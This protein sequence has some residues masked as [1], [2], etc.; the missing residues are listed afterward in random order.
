MSDYTMV[1]EHLFTLDQQAEVRPRRPALGIIGDPGVGKTTFAADAPNVV[2]IMTEQGADGV[3]VRRLPVRGKCETWAEV[4]AAVDHVIANPD[5]V[6]WLALDTL[7]QACELAATHV[8]ERDYNGNWSPKK[9]TECYLSFRQ[10]AETTKK[11]VQGLLA[12]LDE[13]RDLGIG[14]ML[15]CHTGL[16]RQANALGNDFMSFVG[17]MEKQSWD[18]VISWCDQVG[19]ACRD[20]RVIQRQGETKYKAVAISSERWLVFDDGPGRETKSRAGYDMPARIGLSFN[21]YQGYLHS[22]PIGRVIEQ[23]IEALSRAKDEHRVAVLSRLGAD[24]TPDSLRPLGPQKLRQCL[25]W[26]LTKEES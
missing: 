10:G 25:N 1:R 7:S 2:M 23:I 20:E 14:I 22:D 18:A 12:R 3:P 16:A 19:H 24:A 9:G 17:R 4:L 8:C 21:E 26:L 5:G 11:E 13:L 6:D 15:L